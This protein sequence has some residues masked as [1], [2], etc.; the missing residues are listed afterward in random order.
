MA[1][2]RP[3]VPL[4]LA[5]ALGWAPVLRAQEFDFMAGGMRTTSPVHS[6]YAY[7]VDYI[8]DFYRSAAGVLAG[9][10][11]WINEGHVPDHHRDGTAV[12][13]WLRLPFDQGR[14][15]L[16]AGAGVY[17]YYDTQTA[18][19]GV[20]L[21]V[22][23]TAPIVSVAATRYWDNRLFVR[24]L[25]NQISPAGQVK[26]TTAALGLGIWCGSGRRPG[27][28]TDQPPDPADSYV[29]PWETTGCLGES[30]VNTFHSE[31][32]KAF[33]AELRHGLLP[34]V[35]ATLSYLNEGNPEI[36]RRNGT[37]AQAWAVEHFFGQRLSLG[38]GLGPYFYLDRKNPPAQGPGRPPD[39]ALLE[40]LALGWCPAGTWFT[41]LTF[42]R[43]ASNY[44]RDADIYLLGLGRRWGG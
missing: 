26:V 29:T 23:G 43:V 8:Q 3:A 30:V 10:V 5:L 17:N 34:H 40:S 42:N 24:G 33:A 25:V 13:L 21:D 14:L 28:L 15:V 19:A 27:Y 44:N 38:I 22:H 4:L 39:V 11:D 41:R 9:S 35:D 2:L 36:I 37:A 6:S 18:P 7:Q 12:Q 1:V 32:A 20:S 31:R 16:A